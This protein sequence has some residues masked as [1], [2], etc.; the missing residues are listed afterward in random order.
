[1]EQLTGLFRSIEMYRELSQTFEMMK[2]FAPSSDGTKDGAT[3]DGM[4]DMLMNMLSP[5]QK[6]M[7]EMFGGNTHESK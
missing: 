3:E 7:F 5:E 1:M 6:S 2:D 4:L